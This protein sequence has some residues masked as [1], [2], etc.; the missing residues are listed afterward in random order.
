[1]LHIWPSASNHAVNRSVLKLRQLRA[2]IILRLDWLA[3][4]TETLPRRGGFSSFKAVNLLF[5]STSPRKLHIAPGMVNP[6]PVETVSSS[7]AA[8]ATKYRRSTAKPCRYK[9]ERAA[10]GKIPVDKAFSLGGCTAWGWSDRDAWRE[11]SSK[12]ARRVEMRRS[13]ASSEKTGP[14]W[15]FQMPHAG[16]DFYFNGR[17]VSYTRVIFRTG[18]SVPVCMSVPK[19]YATSHCIVGVYNRSGAVNSCPTCIG[20]ISER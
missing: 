19:G 20:F 3:E 18:P 14:K 1:M 4:A 8:A 10:K 7:A 15:T 9:C 11:N 6:S 16:C 12:L 17:S 5:S 2:Q 13:C